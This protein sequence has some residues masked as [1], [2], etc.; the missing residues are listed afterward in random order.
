LVAGLVSFTRP[1]SRRRIIR[2]TTSSVTIGGLGF[3]RLCDDANRGGTFGVGHLTLNTG[4]P[5]S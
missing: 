2:P 1:L 3:D 5:F 4:Q